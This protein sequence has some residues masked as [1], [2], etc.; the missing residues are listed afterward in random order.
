MVKSINLCDKRKDE[1]FVTR[2]RVTV[3]CKAVHIESV[4]RNRTNN[5]TTKQ[6]K[7][8]INLTTGWL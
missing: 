2:H 8:D 5:I 3:P 6:Q 1:N 7:G 4:S